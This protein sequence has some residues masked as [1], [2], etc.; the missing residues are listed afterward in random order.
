MFLL[1]LDRGEQAN[2][3][4]DYMLGARMRGMNATAVDQSDAISAAEKT[5]H[6]VDQSVGCLLSTTR[7]SQMSFWDFG[8]V[9]FE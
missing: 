7:S 6:F 8:G 9:V 1:D 3:H 4:L 5:I 2:F